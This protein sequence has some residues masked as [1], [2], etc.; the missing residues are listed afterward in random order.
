MRVTKTLYQGAEQMFGKHHCLDK[1][2]LPFK[3]AGRMVG[4]EDI[5]SGGRNRVF[6]EHDAAI[7]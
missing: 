2:N 6:E 5:A 7:Q 1:M 3:T 4:D